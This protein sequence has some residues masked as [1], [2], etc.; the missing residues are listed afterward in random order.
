MLHCIH[1]SLTTGATVIWTQP[2][3]SPSSPCG[4]PGRWRPST[5][6]S[7]RPTAANSATWTSSRFVQRVA[8]DAETALP[9]HDWLPHASERFLAAPALEQ[10]DFLEGAADAALALMSAEPGATTAT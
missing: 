7:P 3:A 1:T 6:A 9:L 8:Q 4:C 10:P 2:C 5:P